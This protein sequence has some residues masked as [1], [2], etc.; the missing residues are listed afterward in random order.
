[1]TKRILASLCLLLSLSSQAQE[2]TCL[3]KLMPYSRHSGVHMIAKEEW[4]DGKDGLD[5]ENSLTVIQFLINS[6]LLCRSGEVSIKVNPVC[7]QVIAD[8]PQS[9]VCYAH[10]NVGYFVLSRDNNRN[11]NV[12]FSKDRRFSE[13]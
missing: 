1:M 7:A 11:V 2:M 13:R 12:I 10:S 4:N 6:K 3:D 9:N 5:A 8:L